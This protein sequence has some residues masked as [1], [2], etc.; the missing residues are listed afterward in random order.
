M[1]GGTQEGI[2]DC[3]RSKVPLLGRERGGGV[4][5]H[6][7]LPA[8]MQALRGLGISGTCYQRREVTCS[9]SRGLSAMWCLL[10][11]IQVAGTN[12]GGCLRDQREAWPATIGGL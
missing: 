12:R 6:R 5:H 9:G 2:W 8:H 11:D 7:N 10:G 4:D 3:K 1:A